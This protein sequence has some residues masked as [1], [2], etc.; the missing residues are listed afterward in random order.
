MARDGT[1]RGGGPEMR[2]TLWR[3]ENCNPFI[4]IHAAMMV[5]EALCPVCVSV[6]LK[7]IGSC[8][9]VFLYLFADA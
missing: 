1:D 9:G 6:L 4:A 5:D 3:C 8:D 2:D 7:Y